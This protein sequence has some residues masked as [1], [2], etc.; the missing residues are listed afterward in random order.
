M[1]T[2][3]YI[4]AAAPPPPKRAYRLTLQ[5]TGEVFEVNP[6]AL[7]DEE[8]QRGSV[9]ATLL[10]HDVELDHSCGGVLACATCHI[11]VRAGLESA[12]G[13]IEEEEDQLDFAPA[14]QPCSRLSCQF[15]PDG[16]VDVVVEI[17]AWKRNLVSEG[18]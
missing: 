10:H 5:N 6:D 9:L 1:A 8:G 11:Y 17:P 3:P 14:L 18:H 2:N 15:V 12:P 7:P 16:S 4:D 13:A